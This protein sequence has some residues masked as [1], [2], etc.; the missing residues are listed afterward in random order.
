MPFV[1]CKFGGTSVSTRAQWET[2]AS[3]AQAHLDAGNHPVIVCSA[4]SK[5]SRKLEALLE[6]ALTNGHTSHLEAIKAQHWD[7]ADALGVDGDAL[8][9]HYFDSISRLAY[10]VSLTREV[11]PAVRARVL[12]GGELMLSALGAAYLNA[13]GLQTTWRDARRMLCAE[14]D[15]SAPLHEQY[16]SNQC[17]HDASLELQQRLADDHVTLTQG[18][19]ASNARGETVLIGWGGSDTSASYLAAML[20]AEHVEIWTD[21]PG[22][23]TA[24]PRIIPS[25]RLLQHLNYDE[26]EELASTGAEVLHPRCIDPL[27]AQNIPLEI[28]CT[29]APHLRG[30][31]IAP[32]LDAPGGQVK[33]IAMLP[34]LTLIAIETP[35]MWH[36]VGFLAR[37]C[38]IFERHKLSIGLVATS[39]TN[40]TLSIDP[41]HGFALTPFTLEALLADLNTFCAAHAIQSCA[42]VSLVG[43]QLRSVL[44]EL[45]PALEALSEQ[46][47]YLVTQAASD[48]NFSF[49]VKEPQAVRLVTKLHHQIFGQVR[50]GGVFGPTFRELFD[51]A[52]PADAAWWRQKRSALL[53]I[54]KESSP[55]Y[56]YDAE[57]LKAA[58]VRLLELE[59]VARC[60][61]AMKA[62]HHADV[63]RVFHEAGLG[64]ECV[65]PGELEY[66]YSVFPDLDPDRVLFTPNFAPREEY[67]QGFALARHV[68]L[69]SIRPLELWT[70]LFE[71]RDLFVRV[72]PGRGHGHH[73][74]VR[75]AGAQSKFGVVPETLPRLKRLA[76]SAGARIVGLHAHV[77]SGILAHHTWPEVAQF[78]GSL[79]EGFADVRVLNI[80][81]GL[82]IAERPGTAE[83]ELEALSE[84]LGSFRAAYPNLALWMEPGRF[85]VAEAG[86][87]L[88]RVTQVKQK[89]QTHYV[90]VETGMNSLI[91]PALYG[92]YHEIV[93]LTRLDVPNTVSAEVVGPICET[94]D[95]LGHARRLPD[96]QEGDHL[97]VATAGAYGHVMST[98]YN[99]R[100]P[101]REVLL[102]PSGKPVPQP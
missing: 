82:G 28:R 31:R 38:S 15:R 21:V 17:R 6:A 12:S 81:G 59:P 10:G 50:A 3:I 23:F 34:G 32:G 80:G 27:R 47:I 91:R 62:C 41:I 43:R 79:A 16:L 70:D 55:C 101:A 72:D 44:H 48:R 61:Y 60:F 42:A 99:H 24:D 25:A 98:H 30:T 93:N 19:I 74:H 45:G 13:Q 8:L 26:A 4:V 18:F 102:T 2:V 39:E 11:G 7:L 97:L 58:A 54:A 77:G 96:T 64:F 92:S 36:S 14:T 95:V 49:V 1:V 71:D 67:A 9:S 20:E 35:R 40:V 56:V 94:G 33:A 76:A 88:A 90:G 68:T 29:N 66:L 37:V 46:K 73:K 87:L 63:L 22:M 52:P 69:D 84:G 89:G 86:V 85:L 5:T 53:Q 75:T 100:S 51:P 57:T 65:S 83:L 78:L